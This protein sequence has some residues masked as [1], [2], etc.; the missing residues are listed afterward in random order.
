MRN[1]FQYEKY[2]EYFI[3]DKDKELF[4]N[5]INELNQYFSKPF[6]IIS[7]DDELILK[8]NSDSEILYKIDTYCNVQAYKGKSTIDLDEILFKYPNEFQ[9]YQEL[10]YCLRDDINKQNKEPNFE[11]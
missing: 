6:I 5:I 1:Y 3:S 2:K 11:R 7:Q 9:F 4:T 10:F 8:S